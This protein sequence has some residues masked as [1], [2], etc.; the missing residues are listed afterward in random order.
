MWT[1]PSGFARKSKD[2]PNDLL[3]SIFQCVSGKYYSS[4]P[5]VAT[6]LLNGAGFEAR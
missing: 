6:V 4:M 2:Q 1:S 3:D 5:E